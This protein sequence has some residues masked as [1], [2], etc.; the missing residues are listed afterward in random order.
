MWMKY[1]WFYTIVFNL[2]AWISLKFY[3]VKCWI[4]MV[5]FFSTATTDWL[6]SSWVPPRQISQAQLLC[7]NTRLQKSRDAYWERGDHWIL[8]FLRLLHYFTV[9]LTRSAFEERSSS[10]A[11]VDGYETFCPHFFQIFQIL[12]STILSILKCT[13]SILHY[14]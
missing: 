11:D 9:S 7:R 8:C 3:F 13:V 12:G 5:C 14:H 2:R 6:G 10:S 1:F 4:C